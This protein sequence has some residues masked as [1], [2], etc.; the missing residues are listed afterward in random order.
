[1]LGLFEC[2]SAASGTPGVFDNGEPVDAD[3]FDIEVDHV[4]FTRSAQEN[5]CCQLNS[6]GAGDACH[7]S[8]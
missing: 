1:M 3:I 4:C 5:L 6:Q 2:D 7:G 8:K